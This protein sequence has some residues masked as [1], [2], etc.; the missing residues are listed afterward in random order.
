MNNT[1]ARLLRRGPEGG[2]SAGISTEASGEA[3]APEADGPPATADQIDA[4]FRRVPERKAR[5]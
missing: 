1:L 5:K 4:A 3:G 2:Q